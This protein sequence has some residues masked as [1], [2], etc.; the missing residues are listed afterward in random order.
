MKI[1]KERRITSYPIHSLAK[2]E[3]TAE[4]QFVHLPKESAVR[5]D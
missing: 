2:K 1:K 5:D 3:L 4:S